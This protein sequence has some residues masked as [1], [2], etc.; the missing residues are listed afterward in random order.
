MQLVLRLKTLSDFCIIF[1][2]LFK[3]IPDHLVR[4]SFTRESLLI[5]QK[6]IL[7][8]TTNSTI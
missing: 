2:A 6:V 4:E 3:G 1:L 8:V 7:L 5:P